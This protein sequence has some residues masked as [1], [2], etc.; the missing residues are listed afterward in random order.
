M[1]QPL[2]KSVDPDAVVLAI[3]AKLVVA[4]VSLYVITIGSKLGSL[5]S[6]WVVS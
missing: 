4:T 3:A 1:I 2:T 5:D 6:F